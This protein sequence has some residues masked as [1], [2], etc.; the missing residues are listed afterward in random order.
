MVRRSVVVAVLAGMLVVAAA[1]A[2]WFEPA[3]AQ[4]SGAAQ[5]ET[6]VDVEL[7]LAVDISY[8]MDPD[9]LAL[10]R[11][12]YAQALVSAEF[13][14][15][16]RQGI[17]GRIA[18]TYF[19]WA[20]ATEQRVVVPW[21]V[22]EGPESAGSVAN[23][24]LQAP[25]RRAARTSISGALLFGMKLFDVNPNRGMRRVIDV[26]GDGANNSGQFV[27]IARDEVLSRGITINGLP[28]ML[29]RPSYAT[30]DIELLDD[31]YE[32]CV[33]GGPGS[34]VIPVKEREKFVEAIRTK[35]VLEIAALPAEPRVMKASA[36]NPRVP[37]TIG[38]R[39]WQERWGN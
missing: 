5:Q 3:W 24:I 21:R 14:N 34:F 11:E 1:G 16:L 20:G 39:L 10:Q 33:I 2:A 9:E 37:C 17:H 36:A 4:R 38:E 8:S 31:Y 32:D 28:I 23:D 6:S 18:V 25:I 19:E 15:V 29:K 35:L 7:V 27:T 30:M 12:G 22:V 13:L 26:S